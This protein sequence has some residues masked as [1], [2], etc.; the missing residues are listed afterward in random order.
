METVTVV[1]VDARKKEGEESLILYMHVNK[2]EKFNQERVEIQ[3]FVV[4]REGLEALLKDLHAHLPLAGGVTFYVKG[5]ELSVENNG[6]D[7]RIP[8]SDVSK[9]LLELRRA[10]ELRKIEELTKW[11]ARDTGD[12]IIVYQDLHTKTGECV[13]V[14]LCGN[15]AVVSEQPHIIV[16]HGTITSFGEKM[17]SNEVLKGMKVAQVIMRSCLVIFHNKKKIV[18]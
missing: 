8:L 14:T 13:Q 12:S 6:K 5:E 1:Q 11:S 15:Y 10:E 16:E 7:Y 3:D 18:C 2:G 4:L 17:F 9:L